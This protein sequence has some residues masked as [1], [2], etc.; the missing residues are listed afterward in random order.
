MTSIKAI[1]AVSDRPHRKGLTVAGERHRQAREISRRLAVDIGTPL[2]PAR[3]IP[4]VGSH[5]TGINAIA[6]VI[7]RSHR[8]DL[9]VAGQRHRVARI[10]TR[11]LAV[12]IT[13]P[14]GPGQAVPDIDP[15]VTGIIAITIIKVRPY[16]QGLAVAGE[17]HRQA[18]EI[19]RCLA[20]DITTPLGPG[21]A[22]PDI[23]PHV[24]GVRT[25]NSIVKGR[26]HRHGLAVAG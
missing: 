8:Q 6:V 12:D 17:R 2:A 22:V 10:I 18:R 3:A 11:C 1:T 24:T 5:V 4:T 7:N 19:S 23:D 16:R 9:A 14:L 20:V 26:P 25:T 15:H 21:R 13:T